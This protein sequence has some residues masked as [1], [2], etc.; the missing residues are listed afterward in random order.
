MTEI[1]FTKPKG[2][3]KNVINIDYSLLVKVHREPLIYNNGGKD[4]YMFKA[5]VCLAPYNHSDLYSYTL[6]NREEPDFFEN[7][8]YVVP[9]WK[10]GSKFDLRFGSDGIVMVTD[11]SRVMILENKSLNNFYLDVDYLHVWE[12]GNYP[13]GYSKEDYL[14]LSNSL[15]EVFR[16]QD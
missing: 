8:S 4:V 3:L 2:K 10:D 14:N 16:K 12:W 15:N 9:I 13:D 11:S 7:N 1:R 5:N 6:Y